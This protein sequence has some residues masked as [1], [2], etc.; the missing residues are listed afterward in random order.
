MEVS[1]LGGVPLIAA[2]RFAGPL[3]RAIHTYKYGRRRGL[4]AQLC[5]PLASTVRMLEAGRAVEVLTFVPLHDERQRQ[6]G[7]N[8][9]E[10]IARELGKRLALPVVSGLARI[11]HTPAQV[12]L[13]QAER[14]QNL[15]AAFAWTSRQPPSAGLAVVDDVCTTGATL[16]A[17]G[18]AIRVAGGS[19]A[20][21]LVLARAQTFS[22]A[23]VTSRGTVCLSPNSVTGGLG[24]DG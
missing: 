10:L 5:G 22:P 20:A 14:R 8:Q 16:E 9:A 13:G 12:G 4:A 3:Q 24:A 6:R 11:R 17:V 1:S 2:G 15:V 7:F 19:A 23:A 18:E 21:F